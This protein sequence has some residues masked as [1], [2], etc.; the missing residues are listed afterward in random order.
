MEKGTL[1][2]EQTGFR[3]G[4]NM[5]IRLVSIVNQIG[6]S[7]TVNTPAAGLFVDF[8][9]AFNQLWFNDLMLKLSR[10][11]CPSYLVAWLERYFSSTTAYISINGTTTSTFPIYKGVSQGSYVGPVI[12]IVYRYDILNSMSMLHWKHLFADD[13]VV[14]ISSSAN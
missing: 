10:L 13:F 1:P 9:G 6:Q 12:F 2:D 4:H 14:L 5:A 7:L 11:D 3:K 8:K